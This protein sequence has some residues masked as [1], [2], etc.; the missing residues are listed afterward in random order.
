M[1]K[2]ASTFGSF[3]RLLLRK[4]TAKISHSTLHL[5]TEPER[6]WKSLAYSVNLIKYIFT[7]KLQQN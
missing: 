5:L 7:T 4:R 2:S 3:A 6:Q 1:N